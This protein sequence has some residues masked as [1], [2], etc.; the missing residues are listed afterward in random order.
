MIVIT[1][2]SGNVGTHVVAELAKRGLVVRALTRSPTSARP[3]AANVEWVGAD[4]AEAKSLSA[5]MKGATKVVLITPAHPHMRAH[6]KA[7]V[8][9]AVD[10]GVKRI[11]KLS[12]LG[13]GP[14]APIRLPQEHFA[15]EQCIVA[16]GVA[17]SFVRPNLFMQVLLG[18]ADSIRN[19]GVFYAPAGDG[20][21][22]LTDARDVASALVHEVLRNDDANAVHEITGPDALSYADAAELLGRAVGKRISYVEVEPATARLAM[23]DSGMDPWLAEAFLELF[24]VY[25]AGHGATV[26]AEAFKAC[27]GHQA[28]DF[29]QFAA[30]H[31]AIFQQAA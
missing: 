2:A 12:G 6:Q 27:T 28:R 31:R 9:A 8:A 30:D 22:S 19:D 11:A 4:F 14:D 16:S 29:V 23:T 25:R 1:G 18:S 24:D 3:V 13:A 15:I 10:A 7:L 26:L 17:H 5:A 20:K 21:I